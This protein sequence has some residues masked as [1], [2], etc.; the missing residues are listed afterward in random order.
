MIAI[1]ILGI[2]LLI[3][4]GMFPVA[5]TKARDLSEFTTSTSCTEAAETTVRLL[6]RVANTSDPVD[7]LPSFWGDDDGAG[8][9][10]KGVPLNIDPWVHAVNLQNYDVHT[11]WPPSSPTNLPGIG[12]FL[13]LADGSSIYPYPAPTIRSLARPG[14]QVALQDRVYPPLPPPPGA[15]TP[16]AS[17]SS[18]ASRW[19]SLLEQRRYC[20]SVLAKLDYDVTVHDPAYRPATGPPVPT[21]SSTRSYTLYYVTLHRGQGTNRYARQ[22]SNSAPRYHRPL[23]SP[24]GYGPPPAALAQSEDVLLPVPWRVQIELAP[25]P[26]PPNSET[27]LPTEAYTNLGGQT[28]RI[29]TEMIPRGSYLIDE[30][31]GLVY[32]VAKR[33]IEPANPDRAVLTLDQQVPRASLDDDRSSGSPAYPDDPNE[34]VRTVWV[35]PPAIERDSSGDLVGFTGAQP[36]AG[37]E[38]RTMVFAP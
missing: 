26:V 2:G 38:V 18:Q 16:A 5:W 4:A 6:T 17:F 22:N 1:V 19:R 20:W 11:P 7:S 8:I 28:D 21:R 34:L 35:F 31:N 25:P 13:A 10:S 14:V 32:R 36:V 12:D 3:V 33:E 24:S 23:A 29:V 30:L 9:T 15:A 27:G 37:I